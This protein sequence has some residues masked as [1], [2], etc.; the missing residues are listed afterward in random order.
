MKAKREMV[1]GPQAVANFERGMKQLFQVSKA[2]LSKRERK[3]KMR[4]KRRKP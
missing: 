4:R 3:Y 2:E 1:E